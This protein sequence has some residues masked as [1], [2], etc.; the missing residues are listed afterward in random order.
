M[1]YGDHLRDLPHHQ[2]APRVKEAVKAGTPGRQAARIRLA[3]D[4]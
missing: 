1:S 2:G 4:R 3:D